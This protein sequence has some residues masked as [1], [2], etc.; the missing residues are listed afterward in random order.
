M[1]RRSIMDL[2]GKILGAGGGGFFLFYVK[3]SKINNFKKLLKII[4][5]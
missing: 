4:Q 2:W 5:L 3:S 1:K